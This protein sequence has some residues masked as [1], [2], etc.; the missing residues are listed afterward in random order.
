LLAEVAELHLD[1]AEQFAVGGI[2]ERIGH[3]LQE[4]S[5]GGLELL[6]E[7]LAPLG[8]CFWAFCGPRGS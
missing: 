1:G 7:A 8:G 6:E 2:D 5:G 4:G 3:A